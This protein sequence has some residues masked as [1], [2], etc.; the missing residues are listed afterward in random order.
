MPAMSKIAVS[1]M[2]VVLL[3]VGLGL[4][5][6]AGLDSAGPLPPPRP[7]TP[8]QVAR[9][10]ELKGELRGI[11]LERNVI[12][13]AALLSNRLNELGPDAVPAV[14]TLLEAGAPGI[15]SPEAALLVRFWA[16]HDPQAAAE[17]ALTHSA[18]LSVRPIVAETAIEAWA[19][20]DPQA[21]RKMMEEYVSQVA[22]VISETG[23]SA[24]IRGWYISGQPGW[25][26][27][28]HEHPQD[29]PQQRHLETVILEM[30]QREG[31]QAT[32]DW[33]E[34]FPDDDER[35]KRTVFRAAARDLAKADL[36]A[37]LA[38]CERHCDKPYGEHT[39][40]LIARQWA[41]EDG[42]AAMAWISKA[43]AGDERDRAVWATFADWRR[44]DPEGLMAYVDAMG[45]EGVE[46]WFYP[47]VDRVAMWKSWEDP[48]DAYRWAAL[49]PDEQRRERA[50]ITI[51]WRYREVDEAGADA[52][53]AQS[54][55][56]D[57]AREKARNPPPGFKGRPKAVF[58]NDED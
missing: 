52:W 4:G 9:A 40:A 33:L 12:A 58:S 2:G 32:V 28:I 7:R 44:T 51:S 42:P 37:T 5:Y 6:K 1:V 48:L 36:E 26:E 15:G 16:Q 14:V 41:S 29:W 45:P 31:F 57:E 8:E 21:A 19:T 47:A 53:I 13:R 11:L 54:P 38:W 50:M 49:I 27:F 24:Y 55:L 39:R 56:S 18:P 3:A 34:A 25:L 22:G 10:V 23:E 43:P 17:W 46:P 35:F 20:A 30:I